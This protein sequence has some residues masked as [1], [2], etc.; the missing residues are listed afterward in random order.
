MKK[1]AT[2]ARNA[3]AKPD[4]PSPD[5]VQALCRSTDKWSC[6]PQRQRRRS[7]YRAEL[8]VRE[9]NCRHGPDY[10]QE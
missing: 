7:P 6:R 8:V 5:D 9:V 4:E 2:K 3:D 1:A 10:S